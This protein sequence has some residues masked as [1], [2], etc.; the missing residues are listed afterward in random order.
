MT[1]FEKYLKNHQQKQKT[2]KNVYYVGILSLIAVVAIVV[3]SAS[4]I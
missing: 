1:D 3:N 4:L 2:S